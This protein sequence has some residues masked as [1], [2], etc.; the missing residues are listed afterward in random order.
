MTDPLLEN[1]PPRTI[2]STLRDGYELGLHALLR[3]APIDLASDTGSAIVRWSVPRNRPW[4]IEGARRN[5]G[6]LR[7]D[8]ES[9]EIDG[10]VQRFLDNVGRL[11][12]EFSV[13]HR[14]FPAGRVEVTSA[15][16]ALSPRR[17]GWEPTLAIVLHTG[18]WEVFA[19]G[20]HDRGVS[21]TTFAQPPE[22]WAQRVI[23]SRV[24]RSFGLSLLH[25]DVRGLL[26]ARKELEAGGLVAIF[27][28]EARAGRAM[29]PLFGRPPHRDGNLSV[30]AWLARKTD[31]RIMVG[32][33]R[34]LEK[35]RFVLD[36]TTPFRLPAPTRKPSDQILDD[37]AMLNEVVEPIVRA[38]LDQWYFLDDRID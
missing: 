31:A 13:L 27:G 33:A 16:D 30:A 10:F 1:P 6:L 25:G 36:A 24:R 5:V 9:E 23:A 20:L 3:R 7:P 32:Y 19:A 18:N 35:S 8:L 38:N 15:L 37:V 34:R 21:C 4:I 26:A 11:M 2:S 22:T 12:A 29:A 28:D 17:G 14:L